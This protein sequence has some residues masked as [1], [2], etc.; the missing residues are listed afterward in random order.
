MCWASAC[1]P[2]RITPPANDGLPATPPVQKPGIA[3][4]DVV[5]APAPEGALPDPQ[6]L[7]RIH[8]ADLRRFVAAQNIPETHHPHTLP[9][10]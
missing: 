1:A 5:V 6:R 8:L 7:R 10:F 2:A 9:G 3:M 4:L